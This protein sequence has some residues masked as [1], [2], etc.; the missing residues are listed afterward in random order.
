MTETNL[1]QKRK[2]AMKKLMI[3]TIALASLFF[4]NSLALANK[5]EFEVDKKYSSK[6]KAN[7]CDV[8]LP[9]YIIVWGKGEKGV[10]W[11]LKNHY[12]NHVIFLKDVYTIHKECQ[13]GDQGHMIIRKDVTYFLKS[14]KVGITDKY[15]RFVS[16]DYI[17]KNKTKK[18]MVEV[19]LPDN[20]PD[21]T[22]WLGIIGTVGF[23]RSQPAIIKGVI[24]AGKLVK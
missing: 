22:Y 11:F 7:L 19:S 13:L 2:K 12:A 9:E 8:C 24:R 6:P 17:R 10:K 20:M 23:K 4:S 1:K 16:E 15:Y 14:N 5:I 18:N 21:G 3:I